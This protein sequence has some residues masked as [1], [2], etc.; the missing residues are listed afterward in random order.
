MHA[1]FLMVLC[2]KVFGGKKYQSEKVRGK[3][4]LRYVGRTGGRIEMRC[5]EAQCRFYLSDALA[6]FFKISKFE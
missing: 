6:L 5:K 4:H 1:Q 2:A 3:D